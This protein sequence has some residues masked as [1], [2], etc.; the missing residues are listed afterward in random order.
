[1]LGELAGL[2]V[3]WRGVFPRYTTWLRVVSVLLGLIIAGGRRTLTAS[4][5]ARGRQR[6]NWA[7][8]YLAFSRAPWS[9]AGLFDGVVDVALD[10]QERFCPPAPYLVVAVDDTH[11]P[12]SG[13]RIASARWLREPMSPPFHVN[14]RWGLRYVHLALI[15]PLHGLGHDPR[16]I[17]IAFAPAPALKKPGKKASEQQKTYYKENRKNYTLSQVAI[18]QFRHLRAHLDASAQCERWVLML[19]DGSYTNRTVLGGLPER[20][21]YLGRTRGDL[22]LYRRARGASRKVYGER[23]PTPEGLRQDPNHPWTETPLFYAGALRP[24]RF[25]EMSEVLWPGGGRRRLLRLVVVAP[26]AYRAPGRGSRRLHYREPAYL[27]TTELSTPA[28]Q[29]IQ[30]YLG[31]W[32]IEVEHRDLKSGLGVGHAQVWSDRSV[33]R[34]HSAHVALWSMLKMAALRAH[35]LTRTSAYPPRP[36][37]YPQRPDDRPSQGDIVNALRAELQDHPPQPRS[38]QLPR[39]P[40]TPS[41]LVRQPP[42]SPTL[43]QAV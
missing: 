41:P 25:K 38:P 9:V 27:L 37:W 31:R 4:I 11:L 21:H 17:S 2:L 18:E 14:L 43:R 19:G 20:T 36:G 26:T 7:A 15:A 32:Q 34:L 8:D 10:T 24:V 39:P 29:L 30:A 12:K 42:P 22:A 1:M 35:G 5:G 33:E 28:P 3:V 6:E 40:P 13:K 23:L 16:A